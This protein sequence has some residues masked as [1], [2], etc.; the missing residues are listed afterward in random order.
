MHETL[1]ERDGFKVKLDVRR[2]VGN[3]KCTTAAPGI[4]VLDQETGI[5]TVEDGDRGTIEQYFAGARA[6]PTQA[7]S[8]EQ[9]GRRVFP[10]ILT[11]MFGDKEEADVESE[12]AEDAAQE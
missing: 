12:Q 2:C 7:I 1:Y 5:L 9:Y 6:C 3:G 8:I 11:P 10:L 4:Y